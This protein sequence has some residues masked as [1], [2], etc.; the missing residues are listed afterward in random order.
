MATGS[1]T[2]YSAKAGKHVR[3]Y[4]RGSI[5]TFRSEAGAHR[6]D[7]IVRSRKELVPDGKRAL[8][9]AT[10]SASRLNLPK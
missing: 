3:H 7:A 1:P 6:L 10:H 4:P 9:A 2:E 5:T 8:I